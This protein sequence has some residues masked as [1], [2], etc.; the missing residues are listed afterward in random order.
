MPFGKM[1][2]NKIGARFRGINI[3]L[4]ILVMAAV[5]AI[6]AVIISVI[7][8]RNSRDLI[9][10]TSIEVAARFNT[11]ISKDLALVENASLSKTVSDWFADEENPAKKAAAYDE[12][13]DY[14]NLLHDP[15]MF[16]SVNKTMVEYTFMS[17]TTLTKFAA[18]DKLNWSDPE[19]KRYI[20][21]I[22]SDNPYAL[23]INI[24]KNTGER[25]LWIDHKVM[26]NGIIVGAFG[27]GLQ[28]RP[29]F[30]DIFSLFDNKKIRGYVIDN[31]GIIQMDSTIPAYDS[32]E[33]EIHIHAI[34]S[35]PVFTV[36]IDSFMDSIKGLFD[37]GSQAKA[38][39]LAKGPYGYASIAPIEN[40]DW[41]VVILM[42]RILFADVLYLLPLFLALL[43]VFFLYALA[44][45]LFARRMVFLPLARLIENAQES[46][47]ENAPESA[48]KSG[49]DKT[50]S[51]GDEIDDLAQNIRKMGELI[52]THQ[53]ESERR[54][55]LL[56]AIKNTASIL[57][58]AAV[59]EGF[60]VSLL[61]A[62]EFIG[63]SAD[64]DRVTIWRNVV[65]DGI[66]YFDYQYGWVNSGSR[67]RNSVRTGARFPYGAII[68]LEERLTR[69]EYVNGPVTGLSPAVQDLLRPYE[70][71]SILAVPVH[72]K[73]HFWGFVNFDDCRNERSFTGDEINILGS[74]S[75]MMINAMNLNEQAAKVREALQ[76]TRL[77][78]DAMPLST[79]LWDKNFRRFDCNEEALRLFKIANKHELLERFFDFSPEF[80]SSGQSTKEMALTYLKRALNEGQCVF[81][82]MYRL[83]DG[84]SIPSEVTLVRVRYDEDYVVVA[85]LRDLREYRQMMKK[86]EQR[87]SLLHA[88]NEMA[89][90]L[91]QSEENE[92]GSSLPYCMG[93]IGEAVGVD[94][95]Y[96]WKNH[97]WDGKLRCTRLYEW[98]G[99][100]D[101]QQDDKFTTDVLYDDKF[102][103][104]E[105]TFL[106]GECINDLVRN[107][108]P[109]T[110][111]QLTPRGVLSILMVP[112]FLSGEFWGFL[113]FD[114]CH[115]DRVFSETEVSIL[116]S[117]SLLITNV[118]LHNNMTANI[119]SSAIQLE[120]ALN[121]AR[122][123]SEAKTDFLTSMSHEIRTPLNTVVGLSQL[124]LAA[125]GLS[126]E[127]SSNVEKIYYAGLTLL[128]LANDILDI[129]KIESGKLEL[130][131][132]EYD[133]PSLINNVITQSIIHRGA[134][135]VKFILDINKELP[136]NLYGDDLR[137]RQILNNLLS[138]A[139]KYTREGEVELGIQ[140]TRE[141]TTV[142]M[143]IRVR[144]TGI[145]IHR[146]DMDTMFDEYVKLD[147]KLNRGI[148]GSGLGL[149]IAKKLAE[150]MD[151]SIT[152]ESEY[153]KGSVFTAR[154][155][156]T[157]VNDAVIGPKTVKNLK[158]LR[159]S[160]KLIRKGSKLRRISLPDTRVLV[161]DD[162]ST[163][164]DVAKGMMKP[165][166][167]QIDCVT[168]GQEAIDAIR[169]GKVKYNAVFMDHMMPEMNGIEAA[170]IIREEIGTEYAKTV[171]IIA[172]TANAIV[173]NEEMFLKEGFQAFLPKPLEMS[174]LDAVIKQWVC[175]PEREKHP[176]EKQ[177]K[178]DGETVPDIR[179]GRER[180]MKSSR[181]SGIDRRT[182]GWK[183]SGLDIVKGI[184]HFEND[185]ESYLQVLR[186]YAVNTRP[187]LDTIKRVNR[188]N[189]DDYVIT[190]HGI[191]S[192]SLGICA[193]TVGTAAE[194]LEK[195]ADGGDIEFLN[196]NNPAFLRAAGMLISDIEDMLR[197][198]AS[199]N[200]KPLKTR[201]DDEIL[202]RILSACENFRMDEVD[203]AMEELEYFEY[204]SDDG[205]SAWLRQNVDQM[206][207]DQII[208]KLSSLTKNP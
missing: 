74:A 66:L 142:W 95:V 38:V 149:P 75:L 90:V 78:M 195:A 24:E 20:S 183:I 134:K 143:N 50:N 110:Q 72:I 85:Y 181:R 119:Q 77:I 160:D 102:P 15:H 49:P 46:T 158:N 79:L 111:A 43:A 45:D 81:E 131:P 64:V 55:N 168:S 200:P 100:T 148:E 129:S 120:A 182:L 105:E 40:T 184:A 51:S 96:L 176:E 11:Y 126:E 68:D 32:D 42:N 22:G 161:V 1:Y 91:L 34:D 171:P 94:R 194:A 89:T 198:I 133:I 127:S 167:M 67:M 73:D 62:M 27:S 82:W 155:R 21:C 123:A 193:D 12:M 172:L 128:G 56:R 136:V 191:K 31:E 114:D 207:F 71:K 187:L 60:S 99:A 188:D 106:K 2:K 54:G 25:L 19:D 175:G 154:V 93:M 57:L 179:T 166:G 147:Q 36:A 150:L 204:T 117:A 108:P 7:G 164:L 41:S 173:G 197:K 76:R 159:Y 124:T 17:E 4:I 35:D 135:P 3:L 109:E 132:V 121:E 70:T 86:I 163:N 14:T 153:G 180:R 202:I 199:E 92:M 53:Q 130:V 115:S 112:V 152:V 37:S 201:P 69:G 52:K 61:T 13:M 116:R 97:T 26:K 145:G 122:T 186:S 178:V 23:S 107:L 101:P 103:G 162:T 196:E 189:L 138:N 59:E 18:F 8:A 65:I 33:K 9:T 87:D 30:D 203:A 88:V 190:I 169:D 151:G 206:N 83:P 29:L 5:T 47:R 44:G 80:Q 137:I 139:F 63:N 156:Q 10:S 208:E 165:Y 125:G 185:T 174:S 16:F 98:P 205:L 118:M 140:C 170:R 157:Y 28:I 48:L 58:A 192:S 144:D 39:K 6:I 84:T 104:W 177:V 141:G 146:E 113:G